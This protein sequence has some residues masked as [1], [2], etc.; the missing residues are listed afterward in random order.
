MN[1][2]RLSIIASLLLF[3]GASNAQSGAQVAGIGTNSC[4]EWL[5][6]RKD[7]ELVRLNLIMWLQG[8]LSGLNVASSYT[9]RPTIKLPQ[10]EVLLVGVD[11]FCK[12]KKDGTVQEAADIIFVFLASK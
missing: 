3:V 7:G 9:N 6:L 4:S 8:Y 10:P 1:L 5:N 12:D 2:Y 11:L